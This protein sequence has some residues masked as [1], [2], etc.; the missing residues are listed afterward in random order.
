MPVSYLDLDRLL[1]NALLLSI[2][3]GVMF[4]S[5]QKVAAQT[6]PLS[7]F[8]VDIT[9]TSVSGVSSRLHGGPIRCGILLPH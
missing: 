8:N 4:G 7:G 3:F 9:Q 2:A 5:V 6:S 1:K